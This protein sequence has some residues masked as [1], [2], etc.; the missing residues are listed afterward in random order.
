MTCPDQSPA[1]STLDHALAYQSL[2]WGL[3]SIPPGTKGPNAKGWNN[4]ALI[5][6]S[7]EQ[8]IAE[9]TARPSNGIGL[10]HSASG[11]CAIDVDDLAAFQ[12]V[13]T[14]FGIDLD[15][16]FAGAPRIVGREG[17]DKAIFLVPPGSELKTHKLVWPPNP[18]GTTDPRT[19]RQL[20]I[21]V[22]EMRTG[23]VQDV[24]PPTVH[25][26]TKRPY[27]WRP[28]TEPFGREIP[29]L[30]HALL[31]L[32]QAW[33]SL[34]PQLESVCPWA[35]PTAVTPPPSRLRPTQGAH[36]DVIG[37]FNAAHD[38]A[39]ILAANGYKKKG[40]R[41]LSPTSSTG[42][43]GVVTLEDGRVY[44]HHASDPLNDGH[45]HDAFDLFCI[46]EHNSD[47]G[48]A[49]RAAADLMHLSRLPDL[50]TVDARAIIES[51]ARRK[52]QGSGVTEP[53]VTAALPTANDVP[54]EL[55]RIPGALGALVDHIVDSAIKP[56]RVLSVAAAL[57]FG[58]ACMARIYASMTDLRTNPYIIGVA[59]STGGK[60]HP[61]KI[62]KHALTA[63]GLK[64]RIGGED[65]K[66]GSAVF[67]AVYRSPAVLFQLDEFGLFLK[68]VNSPMAGSFK[69]EIMAQLMTLRTSAN[70][71]V[72]G[73][74]YAANFKAGE[75]RDVEYPNAILHGTTTGDEFWPALASGHV[76]S[77]FLNRFTVVHGND[78]AP[79]VDAPARNPR[80]MPACVVDW[81]ARILTP[82]GGRAG[83]LV[84]VNP[85]TPIVVGESPAAS[86]LLREYAH[87][88]DANARELRGT[89]MDSLWGRAHAQA[90]EYGLIVAGSLNPDEPVITEA[91]A[92][93]AIQ[94]VDYWTRRLVA[95]CQLRIMDDDFDG[96]CEAVQRVLRGGDTR[97]RS[98]TRREIAQRW[99]PWRRL[100]PHEQ[101]AI[102]SAL[103]RNGDAIAGKRQGA[104]GPAAEAWLARE[105]TPAELAPNDDQR[106]A[107]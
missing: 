81:A 43:A 66:S 42:L 8:A 23:D 85:S 78:D 64:D 5:I 103:V 33:P 93:W 83:N 4:P 82:P 22:F 39:A 54:G 77:G 55:T 105:F 6:N 73:P 32:W 14:E 56:Q 76:V 63:V 106:E 28:G 74:E 13:L 16:L 40:K 92:N 50:P 70:S 72:M 102:L 98:F 36:A 10:V 15:E 62:V 58:A 91:A 84:G 67:S 41:Y 87:Q 34:K 48:R 71:V 37:Q 107:G 96:Q 18:A 86:R 100:R 30:P 59:P 1:M 52:T 45:A 44:S 38:A 24:L 53:V 51:S 57:C 3:C 79:R 21:T 90:I 88:C 25:P 89:R 20:P 80:D 17:R 35:K 94:F 65:I 27:T 60:E 26:D 2:G 68:A 97:D 99:R 31:S 12:L 49:V 46:F 47:V 75:R 19:G 69:S 11:T 104:R 101:D 61:R 9:F 29:R 95:D 7:P